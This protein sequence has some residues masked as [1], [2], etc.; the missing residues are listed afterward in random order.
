MRIRGLEDVSLLQCFARRLNDLA[1]NYVSRH[2]LI[3]DR[4]ANSR[5]QVDGLSLQLAH[6]QLSIETFCRPWPDAVL[7][8]ISLHVFASFA[9]FAAVF[10][11]SEVLQRIT[12]AFCVC[13]LWRTQFSGKIYVLNLAGNH[14]V[15]TL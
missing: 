5:A 6:A 14:S 2:A 9:L 4:A 12:Y 8:P 11:T 10:I 3:Q 1:E 7:C 15:V 13:R